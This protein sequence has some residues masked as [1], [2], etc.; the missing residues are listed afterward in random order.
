MDFSEKLSAKYSEQNEENNK[1]RLI[2]NLKQDENVKLLFDISL[3]KAEYEKEQQVRNQFEKQLSEANQI[4]EQVNLYL[5]E[6]QIVNKEFSGSVETFTKIKKLC[7]V[8]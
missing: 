3:T 8:G 4:I 1:L 2:N 7:I 5:T 6:Y